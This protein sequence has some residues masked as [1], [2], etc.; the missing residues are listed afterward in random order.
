LF[1]A[2]LSTGIVGLLL[3]YPLWLGAAFAGWSM[4]GDLSSSFVK[5]R[6]G[7]RSSGR[8]L[9]LDQIPEALLP[10]IALRGPLGLGWL[11]MAVMVVLFTV[12]SL[13]LSRIMFRLG[14][15]DEPY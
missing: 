15:R 7:V 8:A 1:V 5:R 11:D 14:V 13:L 3:G 10:L 2:V 6:L 12:G 9:G 4:L